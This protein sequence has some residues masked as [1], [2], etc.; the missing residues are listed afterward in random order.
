MDRAGAR[1]RGRREQLLGD[2]D[3]SRPT[4][5]RR[6]RTPRPRSADAARPGPHRSTRRPSRPPD[7]GACG[8]CESRSRRDS[9]PGPSRTC[10]SGLFCRVVRLADQLTLARVIAVPLVIVLFAVNF[11]GHDYWATG[12]FIAAMATD[13]FDGRIARRSGVTSAFG[14]LVDPMA[15]KLLVLATLVVLLDQ[16]VFPAWMVATIVDARAAR[17][18]PA[19]RGRRARGRHRRARPRQAEDLGAGDRRRHRGVAA[20]GGVG[21]RAAWWTLVVAL[22]LTWISAADYARVGA[23]ALPQRRGRRRAGP[24]RAAAR[25]PRERADPRAPPGRALGEHRSAARH[26]ETARGDLR[27]S[28]PVRARPSAVSPVSAMAGSYAAG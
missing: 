27:R 26:G 7:R 13:W 9:P 2:R 20:A 3:S 5:R 1:A 17:L 12:V 15:D 19:P 6:A 14:S 11:Q 24:D 22:A 8:R 23:A 25:P 10:H 16:D 18:R 21:N 4:S 28:G